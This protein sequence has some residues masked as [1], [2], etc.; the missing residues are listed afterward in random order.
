MKNI[1]TG[2]SIWDLSLYEKF[3]FRTAVL[4]F[5]SAAGWIFYDSAL[6][7]TAAGVFMLPME[8]QYGKFASEKKKEVLLEQFKDLLYSMS[9]AV[10]TG[11]SLGQAI[12]ESAEF[13]QGTY[14]EKDY[15]MIEI[16]GMVRKMKESNM[17]DVEVLRDFGDRSGI[18]DIKDLA[19]VCTTC[20]ATGGD[21]SK[22]LTDASDLIGDKI[23]L[24]KELKSITAQKRFEGRIVSLAPFLL[25][26]VIRISSP[27]YLQP[28]YSNGRLIS[29]IALALIICGWILIERVNSIEI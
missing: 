26:L 8:K 14:G 15:I 3:L 4:L 11:R 18:D 22:A 24:E 17:P 16:S 21:L 13:W 9:A 10:S 2:Y 29:T 5:S 6:I 19:M 23:T 7:G 27:S 20:K 25:I 12:E 1:L 28:L